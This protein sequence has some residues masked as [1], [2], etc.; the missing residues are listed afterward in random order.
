[1]VDDRSNLPVNLG[2][3]LATAVCVHQADRVC[4]LVDPFEALLRK[5]S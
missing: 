2:V 4:D 3:G 5:G 1:V